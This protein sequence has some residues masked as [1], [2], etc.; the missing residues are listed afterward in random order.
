MWSIIWFFV[1]AVASIAAM[2]LTSLPLW[3]E[4]GDKIV[5]KEVR[6]CESGRPFYWDGG[7]PDE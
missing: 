4:L 2:F 3:L 6:G 1:G 7:P 5:V